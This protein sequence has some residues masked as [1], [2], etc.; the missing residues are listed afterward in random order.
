MEAVPGSSLRRDRVRVLVRGND[1]R[2]GAPVSAHARGRWSHGG[3][4]LRADRGAT[5]RPTPSQD[6]ATF[7]AGITRA[8]A[9]ARTDL[10]IRPDSNWVH[11]HCGQPA[12]ARSSSQLR[13]GVPRGRNLPGTPSRSHP[14]RR[15]S[16]ERAD[17]R[18]GAVRP[19][20][21]DESISRCRASRCRCCRS[22][23][24]WAAR[25]QMPELA[26]TRER[27]WRPRC[28]PPRWP[29][30]PRSHAQT[31]ASLG[32]SHVRRKGTCEASRGCDGR[33]PRV[34]P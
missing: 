12:R 19:W 28:R 17:G 2:S 23:S 32:G 6:A 9:R 10:E 25:A 33:T 20:P 22:H 30:S 29:R 27:N 14:S 1:R 4:R 16:R 8:P 5:S 21:T 3:G 11:V 34:G 26:T 24:R 18:A 15:A 13:P 31:Q 7:P